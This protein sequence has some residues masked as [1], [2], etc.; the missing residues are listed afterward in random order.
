MLFVEGSDVSTSDVS[1]PTSLPTTSL[2]DDVS[3]KGGPAAEEDA[4][5]GP[6]EVSGSGFAAEIA[7]GSLSAVD[8]G[9]DFTEEDVDMRHCMYIIVNETIRLFHTNPHDPFFR[10]TSPTAPGKVEKAAFYDVCR[11][12]NAPTVL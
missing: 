9:G 6:A 3:T 5:G 4:D 12:Y 11:F 7:G 1:T 10:S 2:P 8:I